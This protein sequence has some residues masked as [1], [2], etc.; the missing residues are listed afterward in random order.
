MSLGTALR[1]CPTTAT[2]PTAGE[3]SN[4]ILVRPSRPVE[5][6]HDGRW[7]KG[8][9]EAYRATGGAGECVCAT[10]PHRACSTCN[11]EGEDEVGYL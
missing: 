3:V 7:V 10:G 5:V 8:W 11:D 9:L 4:V 2:P 6:V 1:D